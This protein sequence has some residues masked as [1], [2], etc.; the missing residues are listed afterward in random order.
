MAGG[1][2]LCSWKEILTLLAFFP[3]AVELVLCEGGCVRAWSVFISFGRNLG[4]GLQGELLADFSSAG[5][6]GL[7]H[8]LL[9]PNSLQAE[10]GD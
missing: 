7:P 9:K 6:L 2:L 8:S 4:W 5:E 1:A 10:T 3:F